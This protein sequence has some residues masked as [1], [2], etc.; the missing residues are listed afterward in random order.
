[1]KDLERDV[2]GRSIELFNTLTAASSD[3][4]RHRDRLE[5]RQVGVKVDVE[6]PD[7]VELIPIQ[8][9]SARHTDPERIASMSG[10]ISS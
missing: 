2:D 8:A 7:G 10:H 1:M 5:V 4:P 9:R 3:A 6:A